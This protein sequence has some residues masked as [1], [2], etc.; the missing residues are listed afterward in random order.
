MRDF[1]INE[2]SEDGDDDGEEEP[3]RPVPSWADGD[4]LRLAIESQS[5]SFAS[6][7]HVFRSAL[8]NEIDLVKVFGK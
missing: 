8:V 3:M 2:S 4:E 1:T 7:M 6:Y 5:K